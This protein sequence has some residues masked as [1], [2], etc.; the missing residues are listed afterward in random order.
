MLSA[1]LTL[2]QIV[3]KVCQHR[4]DFVFHNVIVL[5]SPVKRSMSAL[6]NTQVTAPYFELAIIAAEVRWRHLGASLEELPAHSGSD[7]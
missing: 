6:A 3:L 1:L 7:P 5:Q 4:E 2:M